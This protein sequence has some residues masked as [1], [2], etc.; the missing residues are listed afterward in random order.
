LGVVVPGVCD[1]LAGG[2]CEVLA[3]G[4]CCACA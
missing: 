1:E 3:G 4:V 2:V